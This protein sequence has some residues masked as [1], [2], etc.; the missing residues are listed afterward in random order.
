MI[1]FFLANV[2]AGIATSL[3]STGG[4]LV[5]PQMGGFKD[6]ISGLAARVKAS[7]KARN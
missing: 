2:I 3:I 7:E 6:A 4:S 1:F 5:S